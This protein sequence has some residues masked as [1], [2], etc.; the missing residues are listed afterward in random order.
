MTEDSSGPTYVMR[1]SP[2]GTE[3]PVKCPLLLSDY[4]QFMRGVDRGDQ[5]IC[6]YNIILADGPKSGGNDSSV[7]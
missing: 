7:T 3:T 1:H 5:M 4:Q 6:L 2:D